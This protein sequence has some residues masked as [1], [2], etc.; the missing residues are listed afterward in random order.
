MKNKIKQNFYFYYILENS[1]YRYFL[2]TVRNCKKPEQ[3]KEY[4]KLKGWMN[5]GT[6][7]SIGWCDQGYYEDYKPNFIDSNLTYLQIN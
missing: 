1:P 6:V 5:N 7:Y 4:K 2:Y 3:T